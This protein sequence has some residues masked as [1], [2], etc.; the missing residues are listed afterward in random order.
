MTH[1]QTLSPADYRR[2]PWKNGAGRT[3]EI[4][5]HPPRASLDAFD[6]RI[7]IA[8]VARDGP[9]SH[10]A[11]IDRTIVVIAGA[12]MRLQGDGHAVLLGAP[13]EPYAFSGDDTIDCTLLDG[14]V[15]DFN[16]MVRRN[17]GR[18]GITV[19]RGE[20]VRFPPADFHLCYAVAGSYE[21]LLA[22]HLPLVVATDHALL[23][24]D[25]RASSAAL[26]V[27]P[28][29]ADAIGLVAAIDLGA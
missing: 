2:M 29:T 28:L 1:H 24:E 22:G 18:G 17:R 27:S 11:G 26:I 14:A 9:F 5:S 15:R 7:S 23:V 13:Y 20:A 10:F 21:C 6:W 19:V 25:G 4:A 16:L 12:G 8:D 3:T